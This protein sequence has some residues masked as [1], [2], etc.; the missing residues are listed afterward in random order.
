M[1]EI[2]QQATNTFGVFIE[3]AHKAVNGNKAAAARARKASLELGKL[4]KTFRDASLGRQK[5]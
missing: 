1:E 4:M 3:N 2:I 5:D